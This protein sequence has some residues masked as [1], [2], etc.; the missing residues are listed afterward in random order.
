MQKSQTRLWMPLAALLLLAACVSPE[1]RSAMDTAQRQADG[2]ECE[3]IGF[4]PAT[5]AFGDCI[6]RLKAIRAQQA[7]TDAV[8]RANTPSPMWPYGPYGRPYW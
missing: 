6:L 1:E 5:D 4:K 8:N 3:S 2:Q 7:N